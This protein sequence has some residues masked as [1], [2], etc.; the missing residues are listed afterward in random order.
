MP[1]YPGAL[2]F[3]DK[4]EVAPECLPSVLRKRKVIA[5]MLHLHKNPVFRIA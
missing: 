2:L 3:A 5:N 4:P 1:V